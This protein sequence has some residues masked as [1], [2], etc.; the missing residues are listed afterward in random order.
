MVR[1]VDSPKCC[2]TSSTSRFPWFWVSSALRISGS[3]SGNCTST[4]APMTWVMRP[5]L[6]VP[7]CVA[8]L[9]SYRSRIIALPRRK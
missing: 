4:T 5:T 3:W 8:I 7:A 2:A 1:T 9:S 6:F